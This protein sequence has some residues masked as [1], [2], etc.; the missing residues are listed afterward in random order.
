MG[1]TGHTSVETVRGY[2]DDAQLFS[3]PSSSYLGL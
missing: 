3:D 1:T 2:I